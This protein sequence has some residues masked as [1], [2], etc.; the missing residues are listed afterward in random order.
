[1]T[2][3]DTSPA[4]SRW[5]GC[6]RRWHRA[7]GRLPCTARRPCGRPRPALASSRRRSSRYRRR[8]VVDGRQ[9]LS[10]G[11]GTPLSAK[12]TGSVPSTVR[13]THPPIW[14]YSGSGPAAGLPADW[15]KNA[16]AVA[17]VWSA[18]KSAAIKATMAVQAVTRSEPDRS[19]SRPD[20]VADEGHDNRQIRDGSVFS[21]PRRAAIVRP[22]LVT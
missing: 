13:R 2:H 6:I 11:S 1:M 14:Q 5:R 18:T 4:T 10:S 16:P 8:V 7:P 21:L 17:A 9:G 3:D 20:R 22:S 15:S 19:T 12:R